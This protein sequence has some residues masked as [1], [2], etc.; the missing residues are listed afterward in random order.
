MLRSVHL[1]LL[2]C[3]AQPNPLP[4]SYKTMQPKWVDSIS[5]CWLHRFRSGHKSIC[6]VPHSLLNTLSAEQC[7]NS[8]SYWD[9][10]MSVARLHRLNFF[11]V[12][13]CQISL[14]WRGSRPCDI[15]LRRAEPG[16][17][18]D[19][20]PLSDF[21]RCRNHHPFFSMCFQN[22]Y[23]QRFY[24]YTLVF[25]FQS[26][27]P[28]EERILTLEKYTGKAEWFKKKISLRGK[29]LLSFYSAS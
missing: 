26:L 7:W 15:S 27:L 8:R 6:T 9:R 4:L 14:R 21:I 22:T 13:G 19:F 29:M 18:C 1:L 17:T 3:S 16:G 25:I 5:I 11:L 2:A 28:Q 12:Q 24:A 20:I 10:V 23:L